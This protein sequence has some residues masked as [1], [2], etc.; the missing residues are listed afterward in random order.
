L[1]VS[2]DQRKVN[3][4]GMP[5]DAVTLDQAV[6]KIEEFIQEGRP[7]KIFT[8]N[9][10]LFVWARSNPELRRIYE[11]CD[12]LTA[13]GMGIYYASRLLGNPVPEMI[14]ANISTMNT[15]PAR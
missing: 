7:H 13:D 12:L 5:F 14:S 2:A 1:T 10:A 9:A 6:T 11:S 3:F 8:P 15:W 4:L